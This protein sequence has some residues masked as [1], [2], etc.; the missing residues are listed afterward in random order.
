M[1]SI[2][3]LVGRGVKRLETLTQPTNP[4]TVLTGLSLYHYPACPFC[5][6][7]RRVF[8]RQ[9]MGIQLGDIDSVRA[10]GTELMTHGGISQVHCLRIDTESLVR[11]GT[12]PLPLLRVLMRAPKFVSIPLPL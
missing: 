4:T 12:I 8:Q 5:I 7:V 6:K 11:S 10:L 1:R 3:Q 9:N 2:R